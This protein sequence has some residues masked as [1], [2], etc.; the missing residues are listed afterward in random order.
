M[1]Q[2]EM[3]MAEL[4]YWVWLSSIPGVGP[5]KS[6]ILLEHFMEPHAIWNASIKELATIQALSKKDIF[7]LQNE[8][9][10]ESAKLHLDNI[11]KNNITIIPITDEL[12]PENLKN[13]YDPPIVLYKKGSLKNNEK[14]HKNERNSNIFLNL[15]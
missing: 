15:N 13:I 7:N 4:L 3:Q 9:F 12:Y 5:V 2:R 8:K 11:N 10:K 1:L 14:F 6:K